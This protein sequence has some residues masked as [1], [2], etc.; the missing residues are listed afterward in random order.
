MV[1]FGVFWFPVVGIIIS[2]IWFILGVQ[3]RYYFEGFRIQVQEVENEISNELKVVNLKGR[4]FGSVKDVETNFLTWRWK[5]G[6][7]SRL[8]ALVPLLFSVIW[9]LLLS[10]VLITD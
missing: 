10:I 7:L 5:F 1:S 2:I 3:D 4:E 6:S 8:P 9:I